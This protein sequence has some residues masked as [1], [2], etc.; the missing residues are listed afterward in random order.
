MDEQRILLVDDDPGLQ[1][2]VT[3]FLQAN[4]YTVQ[5]AITGKES[6]ASIIDFDPD[7]LI[8]DV[9]L[10]DMTGFEVLQ[11]IR[12]F[13]GVPV[14]MVTGRDHK[15]D[16]I[17]GLDSGAD[18]YLTKPFEPDILLAR[19]RALLRRVPP[20]RLP[21]Q[22]ANGELEIDPKTRTVRVRGEEVDLTPTEYYMLWLL[23]QQPGDVVSHQTMLHNVWGEDTAHGTSYLKVY[24]WHLRRKLERDPHDPHIILT[25]WGIGYR[26]AR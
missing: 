2:M 18:D 22:A 5:S 8:L 17:A 23:A 24:V 26:L 10:P 21:I 16:I 14:L 13:S 1:E 19:M 6:I 9:N 3:L 4:D 25:E 7:M 15:D 11:E 12:Q 20:H